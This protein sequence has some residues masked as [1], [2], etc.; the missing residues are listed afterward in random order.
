MKKN[1]LKLII[2]ILLLDSFLIEGYCQTFKQNFEDAI[3]VLSKELSQKNNNY[4]NV[5]KVFGFDFLKFEEIVKKQK[6]DEEYFILSFNNY[7]EIKRVDRINKSNNFLNYSMF[8]F[9]VDNEITLILISSDIVEND[10][11]LVNI[12]N[13]ELYALELFKLFVFNEKGMEINLELK[14]ENIN[15]AYLLNGNLNVI[16]KLNFTNNNLLSFSKV[17]NTPQGRLEKMI[18]YKSHGAIDNLQN[19]ATQKFIR[20]LH[21]GKNYNTDDDIITLT[22]K[23]I[24]KKS[25]PLFMLNSGYE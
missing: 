13:R 23:P 18:L 20:F 9:K 11:I 7:N 16:N 12:A 3:K 21:I 22:A 25:I 8:F 17:E 19:I 15:F 4:D 6:N 14:T 1:R 5:K 2:I 10:L 24:Q